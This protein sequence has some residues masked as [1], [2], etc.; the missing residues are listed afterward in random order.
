VA[1]ELGLDLFDPRL[2]LLDDRARIGNF[3]HLAPVVGTGPPS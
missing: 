3:R 1:R 2:D